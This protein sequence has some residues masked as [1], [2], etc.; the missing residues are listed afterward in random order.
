M[1]DKVR[2]IETVC[3]AHGVSLQAAALQFP[4]AHPAVA[5]IIPGAA[6]PQ[7]LVANI[8]SVDAPIPSQFWENLKSEGLIDHDAPV[9]DSAVG[10]GK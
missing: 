4:L 5:A 10:S 7:E 6:K 9:P 1:I 2:R 3:D 8:A